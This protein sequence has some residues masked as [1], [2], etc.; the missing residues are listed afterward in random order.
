MIFFKDSEKITISSIQTAYAIWYLSVGLEEISVFWRQTTDTHTYTKRRCN[1][2]TCSDMMQGRRK[3]KHKNKSSESMQITE[4][5]T[6]NKCLT[7]REKKMTLPMQKNRS[8]EFACYVYEIYG[9]KSRLQIK[10]KSWKQ[11]S[12]QKTSTSIKIK[13]V[14]VRAR[15]CT[16]YNV[17][18][19]LKAFSMHKT[20]DLRNNLF[21]PLVLLWVERTRFGFFVV[22][23]QFKVFSR[24]MSVG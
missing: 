4:K 22:V 8:L 3:K 7:K 9:L 6:H 12:S 20:H 10:R 19:H 14:C 2:C 21:L 15:S 13:N 24:W 5:H 16:G 17:P 23:Q 1:R 11:Q 18:K